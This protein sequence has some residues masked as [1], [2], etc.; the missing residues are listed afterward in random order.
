MLL[1]TPL[2]AYLAAQ[3]STDVVCAPAAAALLAN[4][5]S[6]R[7]VIR[8]DKRGTDRGIAGFRK[9]AST[10]KARGYDSAYMAQGS[11]RSGALA[12]A[13]GISDRVGFATSAGKL[14]YTTKIPLVEN[15]HHAARL[16][17][18]GTRDAADDV[19]R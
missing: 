13:A 6:V 18:L 14:F 16:L 9:L 17:S 10:L 11:A 4:N 7:D 8:Y 3:G 19:P 1:T 12:L 5:P 2:L 15:T